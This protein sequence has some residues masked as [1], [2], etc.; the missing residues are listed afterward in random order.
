M[1]PHPCFY[2]DQK[3]GCIKMPLGMEVGLSPEDFVLDGI[4]PPSQKAG[5]APQYLAH[6]YC[7]KRLDESR[8]HLAWR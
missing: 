1:L 5:G 6:V 2:C 7:D 3:A 4:Q 8:W